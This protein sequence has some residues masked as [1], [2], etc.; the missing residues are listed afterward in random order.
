MDILDTQKEA[1]TN[2]LNLNIFLRLQKTQ[3]I[4]ALQGRMKSPTLSHPIPEGRESGQGPH[5]RSVPSV[6]GSEQ[7][8]FTPGLSFLKT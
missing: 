6:S 7:S 1:D 4:Q 8:C 5:P 2:V 3:A